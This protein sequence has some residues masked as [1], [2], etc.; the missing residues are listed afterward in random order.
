MSHRDK[1]GNVLCEHGR[2]FN[3]GECGEEYAREID[4]PPPAR[5]E[6]TG[7]DL[8]LRL[9][10]LIAQWRAK[11]TGDHLGDGLEWCADAL[12]AALRDGT[13]TP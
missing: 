4:A 2:P 8:R 3:C 11:A 1:L 9:T 12:D 7:D 10:G 13:D 6:G 5:P